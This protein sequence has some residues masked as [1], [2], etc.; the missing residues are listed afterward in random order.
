MKLIRNLSCA[1][2]ALAPAVMPALAQTVI[3][4]PTNGQ[5]VSSPFTLDMTAS[6]CSSRTQRLAYPA[7]KGVERF[8][9]GLF[10]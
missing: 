1:C 8:G 3:T 4:S 10:D 6:T 5:E 9:W 2:L 7:C